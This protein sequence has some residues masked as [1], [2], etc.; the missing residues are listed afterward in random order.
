MKG[1][2]T[3]TEI[4][5]YDFGLTPNGHSI[6]FAKTL[7]VETFKQLQKCK[8]GTVTFLLN[9]KYRVHH[10]GSDENI[11]PEGAIGGQYSEEQQTLEIIRNGR[12]KPEL[13]RLA[14]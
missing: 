7:K 8:D 14:V 13:I 3:T 5:S 1:S 2:N 11:A 12:S 4:V 6:T 9:G 10:K